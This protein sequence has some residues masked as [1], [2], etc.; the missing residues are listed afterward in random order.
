VKSSQL[1]ADLAFLAE[2]VVVAR[3]ES[4]LLEDPDRAGVV[5]SGVGVEGTVVDVGDELAER[6]CRDAS[7]SARRGPRAPG[8]ESPDDF[9]ESSDIHE[10][11]WHPAVT[12][13]TEGT[14]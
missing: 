12:G 8:R 14:W 10:S 13:A 7:P 9:G 11:T 1:H 5:L 4:T 3:D 2:A 6:C